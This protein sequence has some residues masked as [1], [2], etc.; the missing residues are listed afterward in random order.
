MSK[1]AAWFLVSA[2]FLSGCKN[3][4]RRTEADAHVA[5][6][7]RPV[8]VTDPNQPIGALTTHTPEVDSSNTEDPTASAPSSEQAFPRGT[9]RQS[10]A[11][12]GNSGAGTGPHIVERVVVGAD[13]AQEPTTRSATC[14][15]ANKPADPEISPGSAVPIRNAVCIAE[16]KATDRGNTV[17]RG[18]E[19][20]ASTQAPPQSWPTTVWY[21][22]ASISG[23]L[24]TC[25]LSPIALDLIRK[26]LGLIG[27]QVNSNRP[28]RRH[29][30]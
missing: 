29:A 23:A 15:T 4:A 27:N 24:F 25:I 28:V 16:T 22:I 3:F 20:P 21:Y 1:S 11:S 19:V 2:I 6:S 10:Q 7:S 18:V 13:G 8:V 26:R 17:R 5:S 30:R 14:R 9:L 12:L